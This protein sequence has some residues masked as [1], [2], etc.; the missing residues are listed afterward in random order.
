MPQPLKIKLRDENIDRIIVNKSFRCQNSISIAQ[1]FVLGQIWQNDQFV[2]FC[3][4]G[5]KY[6]ET[7]PTSDQIFQKSSLCCIDV[8]WIAQRL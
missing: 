7:F 4:V 5:F 6:I 2:T 8:D 3:I 1:T